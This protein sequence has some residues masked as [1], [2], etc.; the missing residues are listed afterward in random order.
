MWG[1]RR[2]CGAIVGVLFGLGLADRAEA[3][4]CVEYLVYPNRTAP[5]DTLLYFEL[6]EGAPPEDVY[7][8]PSAEGADPVAT[9]IVSS[10]SR[11]VVLR[12][13]ELLET[14]NWQIQENA[15]H[16][17]GSFEVVDEVLPAPEVPLVSSSAPRVESMGSCGTSEYVRFTFVDAGAA[18][19]LVEVLESDA[20]TSLE[21]FDFSGQTAHA[22]STRSPYGQGNQVVIGSVACGATVPLA[23]G[24]SAKVRFAAVSADGR[25]SD[26]TEPRET[27]VPAGCS[28]APGGLRP[29]L[30]SWW[31][32]LF[33]ALGRA[34]LRRRERVV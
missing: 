20:A 16:V 14:G 25:V 10:T 1:N 12:P 18:A 6:I 24:R 29:A 28:V 11:H 4:S 9:S 32:L 2:R 5:P 22:F 21:A 3:C 7:L 8:Q 30:G 33:A 34:R 26:W 27:T 23:P 19:I 17:F 13:D 31:I 15:Y